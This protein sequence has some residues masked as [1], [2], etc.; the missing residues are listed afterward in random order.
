MERTKMKR[1]RMERSSLTVVE[2]LPHVVKSRLFLGIYTKSRSVLNVSSNTLVIL[3][4]IVKKTS[5]SY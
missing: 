5:S 3:V 4:R 2:L 1:R